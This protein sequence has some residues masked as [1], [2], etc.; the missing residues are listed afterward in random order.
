MYIE[1]KRQKP[2]VTGAECRDENEQDAIFRLILTR[3]YELCGL[4]FLYKTLHEIFC[5]FKL[6]PEFFKLLKVQ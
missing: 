6:H 5:L 4:I 1:L 3:V 2:G